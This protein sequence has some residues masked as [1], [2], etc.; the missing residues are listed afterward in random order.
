MRAGES[1]EAGGEL[2][3]REQA[4]GEMMMM[5]LRLREGVS[6]EAF[7]GRLGQGLGE[8]YGREL[9]ELA[10]EGLIAWDGERAR[11]TARGRLLGNRV[12][13]RFLAGVDG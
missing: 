3:S 5:G 2:L 13:G 4:M 8:V 10:E 12:F 6:A 9:T 7:R 1:P 11:L